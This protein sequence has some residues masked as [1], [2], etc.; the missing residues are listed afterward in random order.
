VV[1]LDALHRV[2]ARQER[3]LTENVGLDRDD[4]YNTAGDLLEDADDVEAHPLLTYYHPRNEFGYKAV[5]PSASGT[6]EDEEWAR[7]A[8]WAKR[9]K[10]PDGSKLRELHLI[11]PT[12]ALAL[13]IDK[14]AKEN[15]ISAVLYVDRKGQ[16]WDPSPPGPWL[17]E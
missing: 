10:L 4:R 12:R 8:Q 7:L 14:R 3:W 6:L 1:D 2:R 16:W 9:R 11:V 13:K 17:E 5:V 15:G